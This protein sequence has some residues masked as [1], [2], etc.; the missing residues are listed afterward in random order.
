[1]LLVV[2]WIFHIS[3]G[4][5]RYDMYNSVIKT[6]FVSK[7]RNSFLKSRSKQRHVQRI[8]SLCTKI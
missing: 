1:M 7:H 2:Q 3:V 6:F 8:F 4:L 5:S